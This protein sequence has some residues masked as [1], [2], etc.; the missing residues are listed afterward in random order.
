MIRLTI[1]WLF[2]LLGTIGFVVPTYFYI[3]YDSNNPSTFVFESCRGAV[4]TAPKIPPS[5]MFPEFSENAVFKYLF[6][7]NGAPSIERCIE[8]IIPDGLFDGFIAGTFFFIC[9]LFFFIALKKP[10]TF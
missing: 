4:A 5:E 6:P 3:T 8:E 1:R 7:D 9:I 10:G 2:L